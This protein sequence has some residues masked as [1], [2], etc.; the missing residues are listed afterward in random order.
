MALCVGTRPTNSDDV[1]I[2]Q[3]P[4]GLVGQAMQRTCKTAKPSSPSLR[5]SLSGRWSWISRMNNN[6]HSY[7]KGTLWRCISYW[8][9]GYSI[10]ILVYQRVMTLHSR[11]YMLIRRHFHH[12]HW[13]EEG[14]QNMARSLP[15]QNHA[16]FVAILSTWVTCHKSCWR[17]QVVQKAKGRQKDDLFRNVVWWCFT[18]LLSLSWHVI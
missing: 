2:Q 11:W 18:S 13:T 1:Y 14:G 9:W 8:T 4:S 16:H 6:K 12:Q 5:S 3:N 7:R 15:Y 17:S 10:A